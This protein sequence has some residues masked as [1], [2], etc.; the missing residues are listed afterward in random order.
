MDDCSVGFSSSKLYFHPRGNAPVIVTS[1]Y[2]RSMSNH[3]FTRRYVCS[4]CSTA[5]HVCVPTRCPYLST[6]CCMPYTYNTTYSL[7]GL[8]CVPYDVMSRV[9]LPSCLVV[10]RVVAVQVVCDSCD[11]HALCAVSRRALACR[12]K[13]NDLELGSACDLMMSSWL[14]DYCKSLR[15]RFVSSDFSICLALSAH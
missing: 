7:C 1:H 6:Y 9:P 2:H 14:H 11:V 3:E 5:C 4:R 15:S 10:H 13:I 12:T 8:A